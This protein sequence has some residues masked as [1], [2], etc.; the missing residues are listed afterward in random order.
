MKA[1]IRKKNR[2]RKASTDSSSFRKN[3]KSSF[4]SPNSSMKR[5]HSTVVTECAPNRDGRDGKC[6]FCSKE[7][8]SIY[9]KLCKLELCF[10]CTSKRHQLGNLTKH[11]LTLITGDKVTL[12][13]IHGNTPVCE[14]CKRACAIIRCPECNINFCKKCA[15][16][17][18]LVD[19]DH[20]HF[21]VGLAL[22][23]VKFTFQ[24]CKAS[25]NHFLPKSDS[26]TPRGS[27]KN[28]NSKRRSS[29]VKGGKQKSELYS[30]RQKL[31]PKRPTGRRRANTTFESRSPRKKSSSKSRRSSHSK[32]KDFLGGTK[33]TVI[34]GVHKDRKGCIQKKPGSDEAVHKRGG[35]GSFLYAVDLTLDKGPTKTCWI[36]G[37]NLRRRKAGEDSPSNRH[38]SSKKETGTI[39]SQEDVKTL[40]KKMHELID[41][42]DYINAEKV[43]CKLQKLKAR[44]SSSSQDNGNEENKV[45]QTSI[46]LEIG[47]K[48]KMS[49]LFHSQ[50]NH[51]DK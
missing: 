17:F 43:L 5:S 10:R 29:N 6:Q 51:V 49:A 11:P 20:G 21:C 7:E 8:A 32:K 3:K 19:H 30:P 18:H 44:S 25:G 33:V 14:W 48:K 42:M 37:D 1:N 45:R 28:K 39:R 12:T 2:F 41:K 4:V 26:G 24:E 34:S 9:C 50:I 40:E 27:P 15:D 46:S 13:P 38:H 16:D 36:T 23:K 22:H 35:A 31:E 47:K